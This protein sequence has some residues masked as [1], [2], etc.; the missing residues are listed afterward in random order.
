MTDLRDV[1]REFFPSATDAECKEVIWEAGG[2][3]LYLDNPEAL[4]S[5]L[6]KKSR[7]EDLANRF[8]LVGRAS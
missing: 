5:L 7:I 3:D 1:V 8:G 2:Y 6:E 4:R